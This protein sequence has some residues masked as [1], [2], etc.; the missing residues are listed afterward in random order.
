[1]RQPALLAAIVLAAVAPTAIWSP[2]AADIYPRQ[3]YA[4]YVRTCAASE[5]LR[6]YGLA[7]GFEICHCVVKWFEFKMTYK[8]FT[9]EYRKSERGQANKFDAAI[10]EG[11]RFCEK[12]VTDPR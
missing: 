11:G 5:G 6:Q 3:F 4:D 8:E 9:E 1:M 2:A 10:S 12:L 7:L